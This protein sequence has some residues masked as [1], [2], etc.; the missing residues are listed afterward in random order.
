MQPTTTH[1]YHYH[2]RDNDYCPGCISWLMYCEQ[3]FHRYRNSGKHFEFQFADEDYETYP[4][5]VMTTYT[6][7]QSERDLTALARF[8][9]IDREAVSSVDFPVLK[10][11]VPY[12][13]SLCSECLEWFDPIPAHS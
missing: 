10:E 4:S 6:A 11:G 5:Q 12:P 7:E 8:Y 3:R 1:H 2:Y 9:G 13:P